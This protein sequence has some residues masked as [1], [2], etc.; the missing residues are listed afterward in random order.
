MALPRTLRVN[1]VWVKMDGVQSQ[2]QSRPIHKRGADQLFSPFFILL[3]AVPE[4]VLSHIKVRSR[5][6]LLSN[7]CVA[8]CCPRGSLIP[9]KSEEHHIFGALLTKKTVLADV[10]TYNTAVQ[11]SIKQKLTIL[12]LNIS[13]QI[14]FPYIFTLCNM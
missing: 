6:A 2:K 3:L 10:A 7:L 14:L 4:A 13:L 8:P 9:Y 5:S 12:Q 1:P 11:R